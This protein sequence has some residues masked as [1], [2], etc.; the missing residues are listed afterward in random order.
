MFMSVIPPGGHPIVTKNGFDF[1]VRLPNGESKESLIMKN[2]C[3]LVGGKTPKYFYIE[4][5]LILDEVLLR[6][7]RNENYRSNQ[8]P[9]EKHFGVD[10][11]SP[12]EG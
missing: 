1:W 6:W 7:S 3:P 5:K 10:C 4:Q 11:T 8:T 9:T 2:G 12:R